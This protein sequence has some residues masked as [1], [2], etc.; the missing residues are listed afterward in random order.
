MATKTATKLNGVQKV[1]VPDGPY[2]V[3][4][5]L[6]GTRPIL[7]H[8]YKP[9]AL[10]KPGS[11]VKGGISKKVDVPENYVYRNSDEQI[12]FPGINIH[13]CLIEQGRSRQDPRSPRKSA[14]DLMKAAICP[15]DELIPFN[16][17]LTDWEFLDQRRACL[18]GKSAVTRMRPGLLKG[19]TL[20]AHFTVVQ[21]EYVAPDWLLVLINDAGAYQGLGDYRPVFG[22][23]QCASFEVLS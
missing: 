22:R 12:C 8:A 18:N 1:Q 13:A 20:E 4:F 19:W 16:G 11:D 14:R 17:G 23:F 5:T 6:L 3:K 10:A 9:D 21:P 2:R 7:L 15:D